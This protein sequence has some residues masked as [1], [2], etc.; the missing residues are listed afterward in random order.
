[1]RIIRCTWT[2]RA[3]AIRWFTT[4]QLKHEMTNLT[5]A[6]GHDVSDGSLSED[7]IDM[8]SFKAADSTVASV[9]M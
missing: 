2:C 9:E 4:G 5:T 7:A 6:P 3:F 1:M 8:Q